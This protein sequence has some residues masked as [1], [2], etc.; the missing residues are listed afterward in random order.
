MAS[1]DD[2]LAN[3]LA[4]IENFVIA[5]RQELDTHV[6]RNTD[7][8]AVIANNDANVKIVIEA[9]VS[10]IEAT[11]ETKIITM[12]AEHKQAIIDSNN[13]IA[14]AHAQ[15]EADMKAVITKQEAD[16]TAMQAGIIAMQAGMSGINAAIDARVAPVQTE[17]VKQFE[18]LRTEI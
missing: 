12:E 18:R 17:T 9:R 2:A 16:I 15:S 11:V 4:S 13:V 6:Q 8:Y 14:A 7:M 1:M 5:A 3:R 10:A